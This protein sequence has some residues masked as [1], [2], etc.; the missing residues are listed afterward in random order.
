MRWWVPIVTVP[1]LIGLLVILGEFRSGDVPPD[2]WWDY[3]LAAV[4][5]RFFVSDG[6]IRGTM[7]ITLGYL[8]FV[9]YGRLRRSALRHHI[10]LRAAT[11]LALGGI[12]VILFS[13]PFRLYCFLSVGLMSAAILLLPTT[14]TRLARLLSAEPLP[15]LGAA[16]FS[17]YLWHAPMLNI[18]RH[19]DW[20]TLERPSFLSCTVFVVGLT[21]FS[22]ASYF[23]IE[24]PA[25][26]LLLGSR[27]SRN[28]TKDD[29]T[30]SHPAAVK[31]QL[32]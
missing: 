23:Y 27:T 16:S 6:F 28:T 15:L 21:G 26:R 29:F 24:L 9:A 8:V 7:D 19:F 4:E 18:A 17:V 2:L 1:P 13:P 32:K 31:A 20:M 10:S 12:T 5:N 3:A 22:I 11:Y 14:Q 25:Q 30:A